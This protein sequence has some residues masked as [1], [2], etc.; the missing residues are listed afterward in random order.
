VNVPFQEFKGRRR[1]IV[2]LKQKYKNWKNE[3]KCNE[4]KK[5]KAKWKKREC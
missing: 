2:T 3:W 4:I 5:N 1:W